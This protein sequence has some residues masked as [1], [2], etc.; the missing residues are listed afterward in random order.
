MPEFQITAP[1]DKQLIAMKS[2]K[3]HIGYGGARGG[4][5][6]W[7]CRTKASL[8]ALYF[9]ELR[10]LILRRTFPELR[11]NHI[12]PLIKL[13]K[14]KDPVRSER[15]A[16]YNDSKKTFTFP[17]S[18]KIVMG[19]CRRENDVY[20]YQ[21]Q[22]YD[23]IFFDECTH[24]TWKQVEF[25]RTTNRN[26]RNDFTPR[27][28]Y[29]GNPGGVGHIWF[30][31]LF[32]DKKY[33][34]GEKP[35]DYIFIAATVEDNKILMKNDPDY[36]TILD[37]LPEK[38]RQAHRF[39]NWNVFEGQ[40]FEEFTEVAPS[41]EDYKQRRWTHV[42]EPF[43]IPE[44]WK[45]YRS[46]DFGYAKPFS[47]GWWAVDYDGRF[48]RIL[49]Y[50]GCVSNTPNEGIKITPEEQFKR[51]AEIEK[52]HRWLKG[53]KIHGPADPAIWDK[54]RGES[55][56]EKAEK[57][58]IYFE[59]GDHQRLNGWMQI[60]YRLQFDENG[61]P[62]MYIFST[63]EHT[64]RTLPSLQYSEINPEDLDTEGED[65]I[66]DEIRYLCMSSPIKP[67]KRVEATKAHIDPLN[68]IEEKR[69]GRYEVYS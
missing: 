2:H 16:S 66:A 58:G 21:G 40:F 64:I 56:A 45:I 34:P 20:Q 15:I 24:F 36:I 38:M 19:Y 18:S 1:N 41:E 35:D 30:K 26:T 49:E 57:Y 68:L 69:Y 65:H 8:L 13:L 37:S 67:R 52:T 60:H 32:V 29:M 25:I 50:Y 42:I 39:G 10:V 46:Y 28:Y 27:I 5:K 47:F 51:A 22:E 17:N 6:S 4:G 54:S 63:C 55:I 59:K 48:Y 31:R 12:D 44:T 11:E 7:F 62:M 43:E 33:L 61:I 23:V 3:K 53:K 14:S 9:K